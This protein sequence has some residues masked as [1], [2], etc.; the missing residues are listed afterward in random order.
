MIDQK[1]CF[2]IIWTQAGLMM[3]V[4]NPDYLCNI[5]FLSWPFWSLPPPFQIGIG[6]IIKRSNKKLKTTFII[7]ILEPVNN[8]RSLIKSSAYRGFLGSEMQMTQNWEKILS[9]LMSLVHGKFSIVA[10]DQIIP[11]W[12]VEKNQNKGYHKISTV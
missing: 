5:A 11:L 10:W 2:M 1:L 3:L 8:S 6:Q 12:C 4:Q 7:I 9:R